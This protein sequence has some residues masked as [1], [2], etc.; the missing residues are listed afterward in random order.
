MQLAMGCSGTPWSWNIL[1]TLPWSPNW[2]MEASMEDTTTLCSRTGW[3][4][5]VTRVPEAA[6]SAVGAGPAGAA[7]AAGSAVAAG[8][9]GRPVDVFGTW[10][11]LI[12][13]YQGEDLAGEGLLV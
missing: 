4:G 2:R 13:C 12:A 5:M 9:P 8:S 6:G 3:S 1:T 7:K 11:P 10:G